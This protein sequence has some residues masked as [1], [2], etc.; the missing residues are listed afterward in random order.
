VTVEENSALGG[1]GG[2]VLELFARHQRSIDTL[3]LGLPDR[4]VD[5]ASQSSQR[6]LAR[7][8]AKGIASAIAVR[9]QTSSSSAKAKAKSRRQPVARNS[10]LLQ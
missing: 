10:E 7:I 9:L 6:A 4:F 3:V 2:G 1:F 8:D 5:H